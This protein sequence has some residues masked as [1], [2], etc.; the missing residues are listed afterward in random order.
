MPRIRDGLSNSG[1]TRNE[2]WPNSREVHPNKGPAKRTHE[3]ER[4]CAMIKMINRPRTFKAMA[5]FAFAA[6]GASGAFAETEMVNGYTWSYRVNN[7]EATIVAEKDGKYSCAVSPTPT[8]KVSIPPTLNYIKVTSIGREAFKNCAGLTSVTIPEGVKGIEW[9]AFRNCKNL[10]SVT[11]PE[12]VTHID[13]SAFTDCGLTSVTLPSSLKTVG[14]GAFGRC[15][16]LTSVIIPEGVTSIWSDA[17]NGC[18]G[19]KSVVIPDSVTSIGERA[20]LCCRELTSVT[21]P[22]SVMGIGPEAFK[23]CAE[24]A[25]VTMRGERPTSNNS[26][27]KGC[28]K[29]KSIHVPANAK[30]WAGM[31]EWLGIP[32]VFD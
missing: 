24:L 8:G 13:Y 20:F 31:K 5:L 28:G 1:A 9:E 21:I 22:A 30:S 4:L 17:F 29:L 7:G 10:T 18:S 12:G 11:I 25:S 32:L 26:I 16:G 3:E 27:F 23:D 15:V 6:L 2:V 19:L 14:W